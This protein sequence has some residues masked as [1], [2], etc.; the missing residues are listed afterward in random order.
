MSLGRRAVFALYSGKAKRPRGRA[1]KT[2]Y[3]QIAVL[4]T[5]LFVASCGNDS[6]STV[7]DKKE[8]PTLSAATLGDQVI[9]DAADWLEQPPYSN[10]DQ[11]SGARQALMCR[12][13]HSLE[14]GGP[15]MIGPGLYDVFGREA[16]GQGGFQYSPVLKNANFVWTPRALDAWLAQ[17][18]TFLPGNRMAFAGVARQEDRDDL[19]AYLLD[20]TSSVSDN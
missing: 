9:L 13:C 20:V 18:A 14:Q 4:A 15:N 1:L 17:P 3:S 7:S 6:S 16:G 12:A 11:K 8:A 5:M 19:I 2:N 10:A